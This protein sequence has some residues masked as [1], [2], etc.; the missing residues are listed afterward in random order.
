MKKTILK[1]IVVAVVAGLTGGAV[2]HVRAEETP[3]P[4]PAP[5]PEPAA[6]PEA[7]TT[8]QQLAGKVV[9]VDKKSRTVTIDVNGKTYI[10]QLDKKTKINKA[11]AQGQPGAA[12]T[13]DDLRVGEDLQVTVAVTEMPS[14]EVQVN[15]VAVETDL[16]EPAGKAL[17]HDKGKRQGPPVP[18]PGVGTP[19]LGNS[20]GGIVSPNN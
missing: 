1:M 9:A 16:V 15:V 7:K 12:Q 3:T 19:N 4:A 2:S 10:L 14:G 13:I 18:F 11:S 20:G 6:E 8:Q 5:A 17:G